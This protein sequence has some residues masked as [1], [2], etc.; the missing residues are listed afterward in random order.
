MLHKR[1]RHSSRDMFMAKWLNEVSAFCGG[2]E[3]RVRMQIVRRNCAQRLPGSARAL[4]RPLRCN[5]VV[6]QR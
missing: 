2:V 1:A 3:E 5:I 4:K 6:E